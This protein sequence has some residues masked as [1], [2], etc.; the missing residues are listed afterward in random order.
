M[1]VGMK[2]ISV[3][4]KRRVTL[5]RAVFVTLMIQPERAELPATQG[6]GFRQDD[7]LPASALHF[8]LTAWIL[9]GDPGEL[10]PMVLNCC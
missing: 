7:A 5:Q 9:C 10:T 3:N 2:N 4:Q 1:I 8:H 6:S